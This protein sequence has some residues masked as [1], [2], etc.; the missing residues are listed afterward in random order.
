[1]CLH[2]FLINW[3]SQFAATKRYCS[4][5][6]IDRENEKGEILEGDWRKEANFNFQSI[7][8]TGSNMY[9]RAAENMRQTLCQYF[10]EDGAVPFQWNK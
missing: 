1:M 4:T 5:A 3:E 7:K 9:G 8:R 10:L 2:N 6:S